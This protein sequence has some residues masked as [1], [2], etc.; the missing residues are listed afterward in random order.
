[1]KNKLHMTESEMKRI[2]SLHKERIDKE[3]KI[4]KEQNEDIEEDV[5]PGQST[6]RIFA[7]SAA[8]AAGGAGIGALLTI[9]LGGVGAVPGSIIGAGV[10][11]LTGWLT[12]GGGYAER[13]QK[14]F[15]FCRDH[16]SDLTK[17]VNSIDRIRDIADNLRAAVSGLGTDEVLIAKNL[18]KL[19]TIPDLC[20]LSQVY[21]Q[22]YTETLFDAL[23]G[24]IDQDG[25]WRDFVW[26]P[27]SELT[28]NTKKVDTSK[29]KEN[30]KKCGWGTDID[31]YK[32]SGWRCPKNKNVIPNPNPNPSPYPPSP[33]PGGGG[34]SFDF[35][36]I[37]NA[38]KSKCKGTPTPGGGGEEIQNIEWSVTD[39]N[40]P[41]QDTKVS[42][43]T[44]NKLFK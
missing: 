32:N 13:V 4:I 24:D 36:V 44:I 9:P 1:M 5:D 3:R 34:Y 16:R 12:T 31:G 19:K 33:V 29:L 17:P 10:G 28:K 21:N 18:R 14:L 7:G 41:T 35:E 2:L 43:E 37:I 11:A 39:V 27:L 22:R 8:G 40:Q 42:S 26:I 20:K 30:A 25:E 38:I 6:G 23:N 15:K